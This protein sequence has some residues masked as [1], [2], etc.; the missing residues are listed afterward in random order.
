MGLTTNAATRD[1]RCQ[2]DL[3]LSYSEL[4]TLVAVV[5]HYRV[6]GLPVSRPDVSRF[7]SQ[8]EQVGCEGQMRRLEKRGLVERRGSA[9]FTAYAPTSRGIGKVNGWAGRGAE[10]SA[11][12]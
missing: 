3:G 8:E 10:R 11:A 2:D 1:R 9:Q 7:L 4:A 12:E 5:A 6:F